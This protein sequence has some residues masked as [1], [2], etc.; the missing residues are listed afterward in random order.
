MATRSHS[1]QAGILVFGKV[2]ATLSDFIVPLAMVRLL[3]KVEVGVLGALLLIYSTLALV[4]TAGLPET[5][6]YFL[7]TRSLDERRAVAGNV[8]KALLALGA[9]AGALM[10]AAAGLGRIFPGFENALVG[11]GE[12]SVTGGSL[13]YLL[14]LAFLPLGDLPGR[15]LPN[16]LVVEE[17]PRAV[18]GLGVLKSI[19]GALAAIVPLALTDEMWVVVLSVTGFG[20]AYGLLVP[21]TLSRIYR[22]TEKVPSPVS[23][24]QIV[25][26][27][28]PI[29]LTDITSLLNS[30]LDRYLIVFFF[31][32]A[33][34]AEYQAGAWQVPMIA[35]IPYAVGAVYTPRFVELFKDRRPDEAIAIWRQSIAKVALIVIPA[36]MVFVVGAEETMEL[37]FTA[38]YVGAASVFR[39]YSLLT[40][41]R[42]AAFGTVIVATG[43][44]GFVLQA[45]AF[46]FGSNLVLSI[47]LVMILG[48]E[49]PALGTLLA[50]I[51]TVGFYCWCI[52]RSS[53]VPLSR[54]FPFF[55][56][57]RVV[58]LAGVAS[59]PA[60]AFKLTTTLPAGASLAIEAA[61]LLAT[62]AAIGTATGLIGREDWSYMRSWV[63]LK[64]LR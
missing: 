17:R 33:V 42:V 60:V 7:P 6:S 5:L 51:P 58:A 48:F 43:Q 23:V 25:R 1:E 15:M 34:F 31:P 20:L 16:L 36:T 57:L 44:A 8:A 21:F 11:E 41:G 62:F 45:A 63:A 53:G 54:I 26:F 18:A 28:V 3:G 14:V 27:A 35:T 38:D 19:G 50:F 2:L 59:A 40:L 13:K 46:S 32:A 9:G 47:P 64:I 29:G 22:G 12:A 61:L 49:G 56:W 24:A 30:Q 37:L 52:A 55:G 10:L 4:L 39:I